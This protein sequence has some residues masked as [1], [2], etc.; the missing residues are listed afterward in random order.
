ML[1]DNEDDDSASDIAPP[2]NPFDQDTALDAAD[3]DDDEEADYETEDEGDGEVKARR[4]RIRM[5]YMPPTDAP[6][7]KIL[8]AMQLKM[9][10]AFE[11]VKQMWIPSFHSANRLQWNAEGQ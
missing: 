8:K 10:A 2:R 9:S 3:G 1:D 7:G 6:I 11:N 5:T 4:N